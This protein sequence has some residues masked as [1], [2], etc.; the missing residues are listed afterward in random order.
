MINQQSD[1]YPYTIGEAKE[2][3]KTQHMDIY[4]RELMSW[5][6]SEVQQLGRKMLCVNCDAARYGKYCNVCGNILNTAT[7]IV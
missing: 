1:K 3:V 7:R 2:V 6:C 5:L 4:H